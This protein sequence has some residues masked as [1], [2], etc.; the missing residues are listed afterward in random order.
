MI[1]IQ[2]LLQHIAYVSQPQFQNILYMMMKF[3]GY[4]GL[5]RLTKANLRCTGPVHACV[6]EFCFF[7]RCQLPGFNS[8][9]G[10]LAPGSNIIMNS[11]VIK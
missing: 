6:N 11:H 2:F 1:E 4:K 8:S 7:F 5:F 9:L 10:F 3:Q